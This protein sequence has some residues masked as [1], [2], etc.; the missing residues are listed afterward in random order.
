MQTVTIHKDPISGQFTSENRRPGPGRPPGPSSLAVRREANGL[1]CV[2]VH[3][4]LGKS[5]EVLLSSLQGDDPKLAVRVALA[6]LGKAH[7]DDI[8]QESLQQLKLVSKA[9]EY[10]KR[11]DLQ[12]AQR[13]LAQLEI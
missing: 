9:V 13:Y 3:E 12:T 2:M 1:A 4:L 8:T 7:A 11:G 6:V 5:R 10:L